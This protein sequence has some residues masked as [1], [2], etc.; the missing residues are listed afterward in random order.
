[1]YTFDILSDLVGGVPM[2]SNCLTVE[3]ESSATFLF[4]DERSIGPW[5]L[6]DFPGCVSS[7]NVEMRVPGDKQVVATR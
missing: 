3:R 5:P 7:I 4:V 1:M 2:K 6:S